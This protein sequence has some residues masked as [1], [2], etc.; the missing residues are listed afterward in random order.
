MPTMQ[1]ESQTKTQTDNDNKSS[2]QNL[3]KVFM[4]GNSQ[5]VRLPKAFRFDAD[6]DTLEIQK[7]GDSIVLT[8]K[9]ADSSHWDSFFQSL[10]EFD[11]DFAD[12]FNDRNE[13]NQIA[14][15][16]EADKNAKLD[17]MF[18]NK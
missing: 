5:A 10:N 7:V 3:A 6:I 18:S 12:F 9:K 15:L 14:D 11:T 2:E 17:N 1:I 16:A 8:P 4:S 13:L